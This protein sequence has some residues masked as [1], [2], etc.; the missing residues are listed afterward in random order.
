MFY[1]IVELVSRTVEG[2]EVWKLK[3][4]FNVDRL[5]D[6]DQVLGNAVERETLDNVVA[7]DEVA[8]IHTVGEREFYAQVQVV[9]MKNGSLWVDVEEWEKNCT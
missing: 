7:L 3:E 9:K 8:M 4:A 6:L 2:T 5:Y 1:R